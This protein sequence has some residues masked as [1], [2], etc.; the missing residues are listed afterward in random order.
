M[1]NTSFRKNSL[2]LQATNLSLSYFPKPHS[3]QKWL[4][5][6]KFILAFLK[7][8]RAFLFLSHRSTFLCSVMWVYFSLILFWAC[9]CTSIRSCYFWADEVTLISVFWTHLWVSVLL[10]LKTSCWDFISMQLEFC[11]VILKLFL[12]A[13]KDER[14][15]VQYIFFITRYPFS[16]A[17]LFEKLKRQQVWIWRKF[18]KNWAI[19]E[20]KDSCTWFI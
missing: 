4:Y 3:S 14:H 16:A 19:L 8:D 13:C 5:F 9:S 1:I 20:F 6:P 11:S 7:F 10:T 17:F 2:S 15:S 18:W 12:S